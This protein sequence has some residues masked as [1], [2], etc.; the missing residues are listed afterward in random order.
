MDKRY[1]QLALFLV[2]L[3]ILVACTG[4]TDTT[5]SDPVTPDVASEPAEETQ[6]ETETAVTNAVSVSE[7][8]L[9]AEDTVTIASVT[10]DTDGWIV[11]HAEKTA[12]SWLKSTR[13]G[14]QGR[15]TPCSTSM[16]AR[17]ERM[18]SP[19]TTCP[20]LMSGATS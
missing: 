17:P 9:G 12:T 18:N 1:T 14:L 6:A 4:Q 11:I 20:P 8:T 19:A 3:L 15:C 5:A 2:L 7:Q 16:P 10:S 13:P